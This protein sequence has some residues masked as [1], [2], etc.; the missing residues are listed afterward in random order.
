MDSC[1]HKSIHDLTP[2]NITIA[3]IVNAWWSTA[4]P[5]NCASAF[6]EAGIFPYNL[7]HV[8]AN[9]FVRVTNNQDV[10]AP[11]NDEKRLEIAK[12]FYKR[13]FQDV[14]G[15]PSRDCI[16][17]AALLGDAGEV[18]FSSFPHYHEQV[19]PGVL[20]YHF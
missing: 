11:E 16:Q 19:L 3:A 1:V 13:E 12:A 10:A 14:E 6:A 15:I 20:F 2:Q 4:T 17:V 8:L 9:K 7:D 18:L 5:G